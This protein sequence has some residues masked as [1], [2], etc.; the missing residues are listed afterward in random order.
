M[1]QSKLNCWYSIKAHRKKKKLKQKLSH[2]THDVCCGVCLLCKNLDNTT[3]HLTPT[4]IKC[5]IEF[6][7]V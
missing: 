6:S 4:L 7:V 3:E 1:L 5:T 2:Y